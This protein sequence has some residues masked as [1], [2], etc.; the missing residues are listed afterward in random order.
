[1][2]EASVVCL[3]SRR[4]CVRF[5]GSFDRGVTLSW[6]F[7]AAL[8]SAAGYPFD[9]ELCVVELL[10]TPHGHRHRTSGAWYRLSASG[11]AI[12]L[13]FIEA[14]G[15]TGAVTLHAIRLSTSSSIS[16]SNYTTACVGRI[17]SHYHTMTIIS[18]AQD[19]HEAPAGALRRTRSLSRCLHQRSQIMVNGKLRHALP[20]ASGKAGGSHI[21]PHAICWYTCPARP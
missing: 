6:A 18:Q 11:A 13:F 17:V 14:A 19:G 5:G 20:V 3:S 1:M 16:C 8:D 4:V 21:A 9:P 7:G 2:Q 15:V 12:V 10:Q